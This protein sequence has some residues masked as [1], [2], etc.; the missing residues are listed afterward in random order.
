MAAAV[1]PEGTYHVFIMAGRDLPLP[2]IGED[3]R[4]LADYEDPQIKAGDILGKQKIFY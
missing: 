1:P 3:H 4:F 2:Q